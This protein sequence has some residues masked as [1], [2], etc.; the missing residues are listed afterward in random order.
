MHNK[1]V[2]SSLE[3][4]NKRSQ[5]EYLYSLFTIINIDKDEDLQI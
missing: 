5:K 3:V 1:E 2:G 4:P